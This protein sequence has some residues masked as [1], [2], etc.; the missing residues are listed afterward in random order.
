[1]QRKYGLKTT[2]GLLNAEINMKGNESLPMLLLEATAN[3]ELH[4][5]DIKAR[6]VVIDNDIEPRE[7]YKKRLEDFVTVF[8]LALKHGFDQA[9]MQ[10]EIK[11]VRN[12]VKL[13]EGKLTAE[14]IDKTFAY[15]KELEGSTDQLL[16]DM[17]KS[18]GSTD[19]IG[20]MLSEKCKTCQKTECP[21]H[22]LHQKIPQQNAK[23][24]IYRV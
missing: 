12:A 2:T 7:H 11:L 15:E 13:G 10:S 9:V 18:K 19:T 23:H 8:N 14:D 4:G 1:M 24:L 5:I 6:M 16:F 22:P 17:L 20:K 21:N 3:P